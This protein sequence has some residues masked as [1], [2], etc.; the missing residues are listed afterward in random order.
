MRI[1][2]GDAITIGDALVTLNAGRGN[3]LK[4]G[5]RAPLD[6]AIRRIK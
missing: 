6:M 4:I 2:V 1:K 5:I 3:Q